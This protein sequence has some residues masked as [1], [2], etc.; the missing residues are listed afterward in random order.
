MVR[1]DTTCALG[2]SGG[3]VS[4]VSI[5]QSYADLEDVIS[6]AENQEWYEEPFA[7]AGHSLSS[8]CIA[9]F[10]EKFPDKVKI[11]APIST[12]ISGKLSTE[13]HP[14][15]ELKEWKRKG[16]KIEMSKSL[17]GKEKRIKWSSF[18]DRQKYDLLIN[19]DKL[20]M[21]VLLAAGEFDTSTPV[22]HQKL[23]LDKISGRKEFHTIKGS[24]HTFRDEKHLKELKNI[25][26][27]WLKK[28]A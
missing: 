13:A 10:A 18:V 22:K 15:E 16:Y 2:E 7:L 19:A 28:C 11:I 25:F 21:P 23:L 4:D 17:P 5:T 6:W 3:D 26:E 1:F 8:I 20:T 9:L 27:N 24:P 14:R 12:V